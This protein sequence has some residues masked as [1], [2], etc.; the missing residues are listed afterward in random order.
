MGNGIRRITLRSEKGPG[1]RHWL[2][3]YVDGEGALHVDG[4]DIDP[5]LEAVVGGDEAETFHIVRPEHLE[6]L[7]GVLGG[8]PGA[9]VLD[10][11][12]ERCTGKGSYEL[13]AVL[14]SGVI[15]V[16]VGLR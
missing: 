16:E 12:A 1:Q 6:A 13:V 14:R 7:V 15:P 3:A 11:L 9:D 10:V 4:H 2:W 8:E 5:A